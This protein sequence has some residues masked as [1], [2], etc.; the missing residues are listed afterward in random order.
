MHAKHG[1]R[2]ESAEINSRFLTIFQNHSRKKNSLFNKCYW[3]DCIYTCERI[4]LKPSLTHTIYIYIYSN[5]I[6]EQKV[7]AKTIKLLEE[8]VNL[9]YYGCQWFPRY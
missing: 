8:N 3:N 5:W 4:N 1:N 2:K 9:F 6:K 7:I